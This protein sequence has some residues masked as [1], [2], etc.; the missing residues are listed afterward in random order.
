MEKIAIK[1]SGGGGAG[2]TTYDV[3]RTPSMVVSPT[4]TDGGLT[5]SPDGVT[6]NQ[7]NY[8]LIGG[9]LKG[10]APLQ[11]IDYTQGSKSPIRCSITDGTIYFSVSFITSNLDNEADIII[12]IYDGNGDVIE[13]QSVRVSAYTTFPF[14][15]TTWDGELNG[16]NLSISI[17]ADQSTMVGYTYVELG[18]WSFGIQA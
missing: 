10:V 8:N 16:L 14:V 7:Y 9:Q 2:G 17:E 1:G 12:S 15:L 3:I 13:T 6:Y 18:G 4:G 5:L 11:I